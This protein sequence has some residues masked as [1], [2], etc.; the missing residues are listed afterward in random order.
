MVCKKNKTIE[1]ERFKLLRAEG[2][3]ESYVC[4]NCKRAAAKATVVAIEQKEVIV[5]DAPQ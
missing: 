1:W 3:L 4:L 5:N 2:K